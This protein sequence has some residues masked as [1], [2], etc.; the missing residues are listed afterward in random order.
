MT[1]ADRRRLARW[2]GQVAFV[3][4]IGAVGFVAWRRWDDVRAALG[5]TST[6]TTTKTTQAGKTITEQVIESGGW[7]ERA[8]VAGVLGVLAAFGVVLLA[9]LVAAMVNRVI[10]GRFH[11][12]VGGLAF[13]AVDATDEAVED[14]ADAVEALRDDATERGAHTIEALVL[15]RRDVEQLT[16]LVTT[17]R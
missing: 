6:T 15:L 13:E 9:F 10:T 5:A 8:A 14:L 7:Q 12:R 2:L 3:A 17:P 11:V 1:N 16:E 4:T